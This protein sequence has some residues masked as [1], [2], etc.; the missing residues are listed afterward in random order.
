MVALTRD[1]LIHFLKE[2]WNTAVWNLHISCPFMAC[3]LQCELLLVA[4][5][6]RTNTCR[7]IHERDAG[8]R[9]YLNANSA[10]QS[11][12]AKTLGVW[13][14]RQLSTKYSHKKLVWKLEKIMSICVFWFFKHVSIFVPNVVVC[15]SCFVLISIRDR[16]RF[17]I[18]NCC[19]MQCAE[20][21]HPPDE[22]QAGMDLG[23]R[24]WVVV[25][26]IC[27]K[28]VSKHLQHVLIASKF[29]DQWNIEISHEK[30]IKTSNL[31]RKVFVQKQK[32]TNVHTP[33]IGRTNVDQS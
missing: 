33:E 20:C 5:R 26:W 3:L 22:L 9:F 8:K 10:K 14:A 4:Y 18:R 13:N 12:W 16:L 30:K 17:A 1:L 27:R 2:P 11:W 15:F 21:L 24:G 6:S 19:K 32:P 29:R 31:F 28:P 23:V 25:S 7:I